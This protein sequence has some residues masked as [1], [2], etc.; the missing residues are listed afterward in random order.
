MKPFL[1]VDAHGSRLSLQ[2]LSYINDDKHKWSVCIGVPY[3][4]YLWQVA[5]AE[6][7]NGELTRLFTIAKEKLLRKKTHHGLAPSI[8]RTD[9]MPMFAGAWKQ[10]FGDVKMNLKAMSARG[11]SVLNYALLDHPEVTKSMTVDDMKAEYQ[12]VFGKYH[13]EEMP[14]NK[15]LELQLTSSNLTSSIA[16][17]TTG[18]V[19]VRADDLN[20]SRGMGKRVI[21][22]ITTG[23][24]AIQSRATVRKRA[25]LLDES[26]EVFKKSKAL[27]LDNPTGGKLVTHNCYRLNE[28][29]RDGVVRREAI[30][31]IEV[32]K[33]KVK[34][35]DE[36]IEYAEKVKTLVRDSPNIRDYD[37][38]QL[39]ILIV[40]L[41]PKQIGYAKS[42]K[43]GED[44]GVL[45]DR[46]TQL[47]LKAQAGGFPSAPPQPTEIQREAVRVYFE[48]KRRAEEEEM[49]RKEKED[50]PEEMQEGSPD[51]YGTLDGTTL[52]LVLP[53]GFMSVPASNDASEV[54]AV[55][56]GIP[57]MKQIAEEEETPEENI[58]PTQSTIMAEEEE[59]PEENI[60]P[61]QSTNVEENDNVEVDQGVLSKSKK[62]SKYL[63]RRVTKVFNDSNGVARPFKGIVESYDTQRRV[64]LMRYDDD[65]SEEMTIR[66][67]F[68]ILDSQIFDDDTCEEAPSVEEDA[69][70]TT[71]VEDH[72]SNT[73]KKGVSTL[74]ESSGKRNEPVAGE[75]GS[76]TEKKGVST[77]S[78][79]LGKRN[80]P[81]AG[82][83]IGRRGAR[84]RRKRERTDC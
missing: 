43:K 84:K 4:T 60:L 40:F 22:D 56:P 10:S 64:F 72:G 62:T 38:S 35:F 55:V 32:C 29:L 26:S 82:E 19:S 12:E 57:P 79:S 58:L 11:W 66:N 21:D 37:A 45:R 3:G 5:D 81:V 73:E 24:M 74:S 16:P 36:Y 68:H 13:G 23:N 39:G 15:N 65:D 77:L 7:L 67:V 75:D 80:E 63:G 44:I 59:T 61:T 49:M 6:Q 25:K 34:K 83:V 14:S 41:R 53:K 17:T 54:S 76:N 78:E 18:Q 46:A 42:L 8:T 1:L 50:A 47:W 31:N 52:E 28:E 9:V 70:E 33:A 69:Q 27:M 20:F 30:K 71:P 48:N 2:F 51:D